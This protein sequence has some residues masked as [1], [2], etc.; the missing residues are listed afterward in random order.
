MRKEREKQMYSLYP[1]ISN[2]DLYKFRSEINNVDLYIFILF[3]DG[4]SRMNASYMIIN[5]TEPMDYVPL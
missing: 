5:R 3:W 4:R 2:V 1:E